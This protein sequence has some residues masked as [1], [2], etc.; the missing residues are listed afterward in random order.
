MHVVTL[1]NVTKRFDQFV[2]VRELSLQV[3]Q[4]TIFGLLGP[5]GAGKTTTI[6]MITNI[7]GPDTGDITVLGQH[8]SPEIQSR[9]GYLPEERGLYKKMKVGDQLL[10]FAS[11]KGV[12]G[13]EARKRIVDWLAKFELSEWRDKKAG[14]LSKGMQQKV[15]FIAGVLHEPELL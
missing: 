2:A 14:E 7:I 12:P 13:S 10:F 8:A 3:R 9:I 11:L 15:Q 1:D 4:G 6:R 5:N